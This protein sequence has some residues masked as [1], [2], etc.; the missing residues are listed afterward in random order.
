MGINIKLNGI[1]HKNLE[2]LKNSVDP[3]I[4]S[5]L[6]EWYDSHDHVIGHTSGSTGIPKEIRLLKK[7]MIASARLTNEFF[8][9]RPSSNLLLCLSPKYI[10]GKMMI[11]RTI[12]SGAN[13]I[14]VKPSSSP[15]QN[16]T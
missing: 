2:T 13:L 1:R 7:D 4:S 16:I 14:T 5:F 12:L 6:Q 10:A 3:D 15:L 9:I 8:N 11:V